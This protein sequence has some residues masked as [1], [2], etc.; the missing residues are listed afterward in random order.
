ME[1]THQMLTLAY[2]EGIRWMT[3]T[4]HYE[5]G[6]KNTDVATLK[7]KYEE[8]Q[9]VAKSISEDLHIVLGNELLY[10]LDIIE[11][12]K[13]GEAL[14]I[15]ETRYIL[16]EFLP[17][18]TYSELRDGLSRCVMA[19]YIPVLAHTERYLCL[20]KQ[21][22][23]VE[24]LLM[25]G[26]YIQINLSSVL[27]GIMNAQANFCKKML[28]LGYVHFIGTDAHGVT[29]RAPYAKDAVSLIR[30]K[31]GDELVTRLTWDNPMRMLQNK[32]L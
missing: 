6:R 24:E 22:E 14:T 26:A 19:G 20:V 18:V 29:S 32:H 27:G 10:S 21:P 2:Q 11:A 5:I 17:K 30:K 13:R 31:Y 12:L 25:V 4:P 3:A 7:S 9:K 28:S 23:L 16:V 8:V 1:Q 15:Q